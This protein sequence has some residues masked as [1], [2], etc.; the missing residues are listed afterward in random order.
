MKIM[1]HPVFNYP[2]I[3]RK[4]KIKMMEANSIVY[5]LYQF[6][7]FSHRYTIMPNTE[8]PK[9]GKRI[10][11]HFIEETGVQFRYEYSTIRK[12]YMNDPDDF[13]EYWDNRAKT[14]ATFLKMVYGK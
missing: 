14:K 9:H 6:H 10:T 8:T 12:Y 5:G 1:H 11:L 3:I 2:Y 13:K 7:D 4:E